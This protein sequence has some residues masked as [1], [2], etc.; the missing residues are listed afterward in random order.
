MAAAP[1][2]VRPSKSCGR[3]SRKPAVA[4]CTR[5]ASSICRG[6][7]VPT[8]VGIKCTAC[9]EQASR[10]GGR[11]AWLLPVAAVT[12]ALVVGAVVLTALLG[13]EDDDARPSVL[14]GESTSSRGV[15]FEGAGGVSI[16]GTLTLPDRAVPQAGLAGVVILNGLGPTDR[17]G[18]AVQGGAPDDLYRDVSDAL[19]QEGVVTLRFDKRGTGRT[20]LPAGTPLRF[21]DIVSDAAAAL[22]FLAERSEVDP[23][24]LA[25]VGHEEGGLVAMALAAGEPRI[26]GLALISVPGRPLLD[27]LAD[28]FGGAA[29]RNVAELRSV[30]GTLLATGAL[31]AMIPP[32]LAGYFPADKQA[33]LEDLFSLD[34]LALAA[35]VDVPVLLLRGGNATLVTAADETALLGALPTGE[36]FVAPGAG[37]SLALVDEPDPAGGGAEDHDAIGSAPTRERSAEAVA[38]LVT[39]LTG[40]TRG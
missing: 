27:V 4:T 19:V 36:A 21:D 25:V 5:C 15:Q 26:R 18:V 28:D 17:D 20:L 34:P 38:R 33:Y 16:A 14:R 13:G 29:H 22:S 23:G 30:V 3:H 1:P 6:C 24:R 32:S 10:R 37:P 2:A 31:P 11:P 8:S 9:T 40:A 35:K 39:F 12:A 7:M